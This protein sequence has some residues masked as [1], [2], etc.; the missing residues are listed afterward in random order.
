MTFVYNK[1]WCLVSIACI[2]SSILWPAQTCSLKLHL[3]GLVSYQIM[4]TCNLIP[5][6]KQYMAMVPYQ[7]IQLLDNHIAIS[8]RKNYGKKKIISTATMPYDCS[9]YKTILRTR[10]VNQDCVYLL[11]FV[12]Q[13][14]P[15]RGFA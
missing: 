2:D 1:V 3:C 9:F 11:L 12:S 6:S 8:S 14:H 5:T 15:G 10:A 7:I 13:I 4:A